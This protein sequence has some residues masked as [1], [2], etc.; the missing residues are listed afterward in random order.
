MCWGTLCSSPEGECSVEIFQKLQKWATGSSDEQAYV[1]LT[2]ICSKF[3]PASL[4]NSYLDDPVRRWCPPLPP[5]SPLALVLSPP[6][7]KMSLQHECTR[8]QEK[9]Q[10][11]VSST[12]KCPVWGMRFLLFLRMRSWATKQSFYLPRPGSTTRPQ[13][14]LFTWV[15]QIK[16]LETRHLE[17]MGSHMLHIIYIRACSSTTNAIKHR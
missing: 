4:F 13:L 2:Y 6:P 12:S 8:V 9:T 16:L 15:A 5:T 7:C 17:R 3:T 1:L 11:T 14:L 10:D